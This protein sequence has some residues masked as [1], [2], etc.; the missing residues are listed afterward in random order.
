MQTEQQYGAEQIRVLEGLEAVRNTP[1]MYI[2]NTGLEGLHQLVWEVVDNAVDEALAGYCSEISVLVKLDSSVTVEDNGRGI[3]TDIHPTEGIPAAEVVMTMLHAGGKFDKDS[4][5]VSGGLHGVGVSVVNALAEFLK[6]EI[7][8]EGKVFKQEFRKGKKVTG[9]EVIGETNRSGT[10]IT[11][12]ADEKIFSDAELSYETIAARLRELAFLNKGLK[13]N[14][15]DERSNKQRLSYHYD[16]GIVSFVEHLNRAKKTMDDRPIYMYGEKDDYIVEC[17]LQYNDGYSET[18]FSY[19][20]NINTFEGGT[21]LSGF[22]AAL[23][24]T[25]NQYAQSH[26]LIKNA[27]NQINITGEDLREG[28]TAV[29]SVKLLSPQFDSQTKSKL[30]N[31]EIKGVVEQ[32]INERLSEYLEENPQNAKWIVMKALEA[33][34]AREAARKAREL[35]RRKTALEST[36]LP[37]KLADCQEKDPAK[38]EIFIV[39]GDSAGGSAKQGRDRKIQAILPLRGKI[40]NVE[41]ARFDKMLQNQE[42]RSLITALGTGIGKEDFDINKIRY[43]KIIIMTDAD[44]DGSH[45]RTLLLTFF[46]RWMP[47]LINKG[48]LYFAQPPLFKVK[49]G[50][51]EIYIKHESE[52]DDIVL[53]NGVEGAKLKKI[54]GEYLE[55]TELVNTLKSLLRMERILDVFERKE[56]DKSIIKALIS[57]KVDKSFLENAESVETVSES[58]KNALEQDHKGVNVSAIN[59]KKDIEKSKF[60]LEVVSQRNGITRKTIIDHE[61]LVSPTFGEAASIMD[62][63]EGFGEPPYTLE[64]DKE[65]ITAN[66]LTSLVERVMEKGYKNM[67][68]QRYKGLGEMNADQLWETTMNPENRKILQVNV[69]DAVKANE[70]FSTLMGDQVEPRREFIEKNALNVINL[71]Y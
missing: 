33:G 17:A 43:H 5:K 37:G 52:L 69:E 7:R 60:F 53:K 31:M 14:Y 6:V 56:M 34:R 10:K 48:Y 47:D 64:T 11:F 12:K 20:N 36:T 41:K 42:I 57:L 30:G 55:G 46:F 32:L 24:R 25:L 18:I 1:G 21:H 13:I 8:R 16:G 63:V 29:L 3:P 51:K 22:R 28:L 59:S 23:T 27:K 68:V 49:K 39:E 9:L 4:Y 67:N 61:L 66:S 58:L 35:T 62:K 71:D 45:I 19:C 54:D 40:L 38:S 2:G 44:V 15:E 65:I 26:N 50:K 70:I